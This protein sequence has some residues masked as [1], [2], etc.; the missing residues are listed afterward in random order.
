VAPAVAVL[1]LAP[2][3][4]PRWAFMWALAA[5]IFV[6]CKW[7]TW[8]TWL[9]GGA[10]PAWRHLA[11]WLAWPGMDA[12]AFLEGGDED[13][14]RPRE[15]AFAAVK[16]LVG[17]ALTWLAIWGPA[18]APER[19]HPLLYGWLGMI[20]LVFVL[21]FG[22]F[23]LLSCA[24]RAAG[25]DARPLM[26]APILATSV[27]EFWGRRW[28]RA[29]RDLTHRFLYGPLARR[30]GAAPALALA[31]LASGLVHDLV[32]SL[33]A[34]GGWGLPTLYFALQAGAIAVERSRPGR[35]LGL[36]RGGRGWAFAVLAVAAPA[37]VLFHPPFVRGVILPFLDA[38]GQEMR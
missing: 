6:G 29:F 8:W 36:G 34:R 16:L 21:H 27:G 38:L 18:A 15:W 4:L 10:A 28:N 13:P 14:P 11:Y 20:G 3:G 32:L 33:P 31:F 5:A 35:A 19:V 26:A 1:L 24:W 25:V 17:I 12:P 22:S 23:H 2:P 30:L 37:G 7:L 9:G